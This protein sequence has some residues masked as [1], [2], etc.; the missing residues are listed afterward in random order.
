M[1]TITLQTTPEAWRWLHG[2]LSISLRRSKPTC[3]RGMVW[4]CTSQKVL[5]LKMQGWCE[6]WS[7]RAV[8]V[9]RRP[10]YNQY[11]NFLDGN[12]CVADYPWGMEVVAWTTFHLIE[13][14]Q[15][16]VW[17][18]HGLRLHITECSLPQDA[19]LMWELVYLGSLSFQK[20]SLQPVELV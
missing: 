6:S 1:E 20:A 9:F 5:S 8:W 17:E 18:G 15:T 16:H 7:S 10:V 2:Q 4:G 3:E 12:Y 13:K 11:Y 14:K 19:G